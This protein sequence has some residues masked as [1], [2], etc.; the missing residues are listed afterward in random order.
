MCILTLLG[1]SDNQISLLSFL[2]HF[3]IHVK[4]GINLKYWFFFPTLPPYDVLFSGPNAQKDLWPWFCY[5]CY[6]F[7]IKYCW[8]FSPS[9]NIKDKRGKQLQ[10]KNMKIFIRLDPGPIFQDHRTE[11]CLKRSSSQPVATPSCCSYWALGRRAKG[12]PERKNVCVWG[13]RPWLSMI[14]TAAPPI[15]SDVTRLHFHSTF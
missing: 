3:Y 5:S 6:F 1:E 15:C 4:T 12:E 9:R 14:E 10:F 7:P 11:S 13:Q 8:L 2:S